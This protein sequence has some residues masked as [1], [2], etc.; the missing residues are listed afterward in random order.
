[1]KKYEERTSPE[2]KYQALVETKCEL[3]GN[4]TT[5]K[6]KTE[7]FDALE[8]EVKLKTGSSYPEGGFGEEITIDICPD[9]FMTK[10]VPWVKSNGG[11]PTTK[12]WDL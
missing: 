8:V 11:E 10:L 3:C 1:M 9:C 7:A 2:T 6:W 5:N 12:E 4:T